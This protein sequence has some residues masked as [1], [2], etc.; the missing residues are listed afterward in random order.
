MIS[1]IPL[2]ILAILSLFMAFI[3][4]YLAI[5]LIHYAAWINGLF[6]GLNDRTSH[7][8][9]IPLFGGVAIFTA[10]ILT[11]ITIGE[12]YFD[13]KFGYIIAGLIIIFIAGIK[14][15]LTVS[16]PKKKLLGQILVTIYIS[17]L[18]DIRISNL[19]DFLKIGDIPWILSIVLTMFVLI[20]IINGFNLI[21]GIDGL[22]SGEG[23][24]I[25]LVLGLWF[26]VTGN[27]NYTI[28]SFALAGSLI[29]F[30]YF[31]VFSKKCKL[32]LGDAGSLIVGL[33]LGIMVIRFLQ[34][35]PYVKGIAV[36]KST[37]AFA[38]SL[39]IVP[40]F[41][42]L[43]IFTIRIVQGKSPF[44]A[45][46]QHIHHR[47]LELGLNHLQSTLILLFFNLTLIIICYLLQDIG[48]LFLVGILLGLSVLLTQILLNL[49][50]K[51]MSR[52]PK[53][54]RPLLL[55]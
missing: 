41:D 19:H 2:W 13:P 43:R 47:L 25:S 23:I 52:D 11:T 26:Y 1:V 48:T 10:F 6:A 8:Y 32:F 12:S 34:L 40:L 20:V 44:S 4:A 9:Q 37:P 24:L 49:V 46:R 21:D 22:A 27:F 42:T 55:S 45:D 30:F 53:L 50:R 5:P 31:N 29:A 16:K 36:I 38:I 35:E 14:D 3:I 33:I 7:T 54:N 18:A 39:F 15:D 51:R 28:V 17:V